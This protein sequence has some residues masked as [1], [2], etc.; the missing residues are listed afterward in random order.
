MT[1]SRWGAE[2]GGRTRR[3]VAQQ[4]AEDRQRIKPA[5]SAGAEQRG[6]HLLSV[7]AEPRAISAGH[8]AIHD[9]IKDK[10]QAQNI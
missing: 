6:Q 10:V 2:R 8:F 5:L 9:L 7:C 1:S 4:I 3:G